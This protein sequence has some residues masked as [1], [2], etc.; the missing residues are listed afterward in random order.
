MQRKFC[1]HR[2][3]FLSTPSARRAT[4]RLRLRQLRIT[5]SIHAL[6]EEGDPIATK[7]RNFA[8][9]ISIHA[10]REEGDHCRP[11]CRPSL[12]NF[13]PRPPRGGRPTPRTTPARFGTFLSTPSARRATA[14]FRPSAA[15]CIN[16][17]PRPP[18]GGRLLRFHKSRLRSLI[19]IH[20]LREEG[21]AEV[22][23]LRFS[24]VNFYPRPPR[25]GRPG[26]VQGR[27]LRPDISIHALREEGDNGPCKD[28]LD[29]L[30]FLSTPSARRATAP[31]A[32]SGCTSRFLSTPSARRATCRG[33]RSG[34]KPLH[35]YPRPPRGGRRT[36]HFHVTL[37]GQFLST[38]SARRAT[39]KTETKSLFSNKLYNILHEFRRALIY[40]GSKSYPNHAK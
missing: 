2:N 15:D 26:A 27:D 7:K 17:Y 1:T 29:K 5:I 36:F 3:G 14:I 37:S 28:A 21:D 9:S 39:A 12:R 20:A 30:E 31:M 38:P 4:H 24:G 10:L 18:R 33:Q 40:N 35:F 22:V 6:R 16:F 13:Y 23:R 19:S 25:G 11:S 8:F 34:R 32:A